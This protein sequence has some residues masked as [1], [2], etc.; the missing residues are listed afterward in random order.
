MTNITKL[1][2]SPYYIQGHHVLHIAL[3]TLQN[4]QD[5]PTCN[6]NLCQQPEITQ[7]GNP[8]KAYPGGGRILRNHTVCKTKV[9]YDLIN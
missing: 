3:Y 9:L 1:K 5:M 4:G 6:M 8:V 2:T 7:K